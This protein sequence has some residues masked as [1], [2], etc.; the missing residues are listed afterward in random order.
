[1]HR[2]S[3]VRRTPH[4]RPKA[5]AVISLPARHCGLPKWRELSQ[6]ALGT[7]R[8]RVCGGLRSCFSRPQ[9]HRHPKEPVHEP[10]NDREQDDASGHGGELRGGCQQAEADDEGRGARWRMWRRENDKKSHGDQN[11]KR[12]RANVGERHPGFQDTRRGEEAKDGKGRVAGQQ[13]HPMSDERIAWAC[14]GTQWCL[15]KE[16][17]GWSQ[18]GEKQRLAQEKGSE[19]TD[20]DA[21]GTGT[22][23]VHC[24]A[25]PSESFLE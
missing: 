12:C 14:L 15:E 11:R 22:C 2:I 10:A 6:Q 19:P 9:W 3:A 1:M 8:A 16:K 5:R 20:S 18:A 7:C 23:R 25:P 21:H 17:H 24:L 4:A 13:R